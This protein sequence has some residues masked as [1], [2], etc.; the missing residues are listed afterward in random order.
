MPSR[1]LFE[2]FQNDG[3]AIRMFDLF[4][5]IQGAKDGE[6]SCRQVIAVAKPCHLMPL[7]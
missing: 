2:Q 4:G 6:S 3:A 5:I 7:S 1:S